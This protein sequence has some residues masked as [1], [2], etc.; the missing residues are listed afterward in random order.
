[1]STICQGFRHFSGIF[2]S[3][4]LAKFATSSIR[5]NVDFNSLTLPVLRLLSS[6]EQGCKD[7]KIYIHKPKL[8][9][10][11][12]H[13]EALTEYLIISQVFESFCTGEI[14]NLGSIRVNQNVTR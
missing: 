3:F 12:S 14:S 13:C 1:M 8:C 7:L 4:L 11:G 10:V 9:H 6:K 2:A 5:V